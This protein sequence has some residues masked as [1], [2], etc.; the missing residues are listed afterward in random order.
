MIEDNEISKEKMKLKQNIEGN[1]F[2]CGIH[3][4]QFN[5]PDKMLSYLSFRNNGEADK[6]RKRGLHSHFTG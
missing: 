3:E 1:I 6:K 5:D 2:L 4:T